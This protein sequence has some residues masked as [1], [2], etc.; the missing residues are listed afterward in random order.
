MEPS[1]FGGNIVLD[2][3]DAHSTSKMLQELIYFSLVTQTTLG[4]EDLS[5]TLGAPRIIASFQTILGQLYLAVVV[6]RLVGIA[7]SDAENK[8]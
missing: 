7:T 4:Y 2:A 6:A 8:E 1:A 3:S 5:T